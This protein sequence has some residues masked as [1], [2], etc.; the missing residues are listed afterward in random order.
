MTKTLRNIAIVAA[1]A[2][3]KTYAPGGGT[4]GAIV[5]QAV[6]I[7]FLVSIGWFASVM[8]RQHRVTLYSLGD[9]RRATLY[10]AIGV[11]VLTLTGT[12]RMLATGP[13]VLLWIILVAGA[14]YTVI[15]IV[16]SARSY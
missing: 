5:T 8:Y 12:S 14:A 16:W 1:L 7:A 4:A 3:L 2:A 6:S 9:G 10:A 13:G 15:A 11:A